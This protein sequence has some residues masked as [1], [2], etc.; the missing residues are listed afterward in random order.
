MFFAYSYTIIGKTEIVIL[1][2]FFVTINCNSY[3]FAG[4]SD[5][6]VVQIPED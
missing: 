3:P 4:I 2:I 6:I 5:G 1:R